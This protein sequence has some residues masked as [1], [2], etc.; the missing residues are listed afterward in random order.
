MAQAVSY[1]FIAMKAIS[2][3]AFASDC[4]SVRCSVFTFETVNF[5]SGD[6]GDH[7]AGGTD[8]A[9]KTVEFPADL[10]LVTGVG[11]T[12]VF[13][14]RHGQWLD[15]HGWQTS[16]SVLTNGAWTPAPP[17]VSCGCTRFEGNGMISFCCAA[18]I[19]CV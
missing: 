9:S 3:G 1:D 8:L 18:T 19:R 13:I 7:T 16:Y 17:P 6:S 4:T 5:S 2:T 10:P 15:E 11:G 14:G 12:S